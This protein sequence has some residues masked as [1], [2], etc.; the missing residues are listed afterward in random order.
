[1]FAARGGNA[2]VVSKLLDHVGEDRRE[3]YV[4][5]KNNKGETPLHFATRSGEIK[6]VEELLQYVNDKERY[7]KSENNK[8][9]TPLHFA[10]KSGEIKVV[11]KLLQYV[12]DKERYVKS[13]NNKGETPLH[14]AAESGNVEVVKGLLKCV[15]KGKE[16]NYIEF[17]NNDSRNA[18]EVAISYGNSKVFSELLKYIKNSK[19]KQYY[20]DFKKQVSGSEKGNVYSLDD[21]QTKGRVEERKKQRNKELIT[22]KTHS[23]SEA[24]KDDNNPCSQSESPTSPYSKKRSR[25]SDGNTQKPPEKKVALDDSLGQN[26]DIEESVGSHQKEDEFYKQDSDRKSD[27]EAND[28]RSDSTGSQKEEG[29]TL[30]HDA[31][32]LG[33]NSLALDNQLRRR[34][35]SFER[36]NSGQESGL[37]NGNNF[38]KQESASSYKSYEQQDSNRESNSEKG[39]S[40]SNNSNNNSKKQESILEKDLYVSSSDDEKDSRSLVGD[41]LRLDK[42]DLCVSSSNYKD[43]DLSDDYDSD[44][45]S[46]N[47]ESVCGSPEQNSSGPLE[48][49][50]NS[51]ERND[52][53]NISLQNDASE[54]ER[55]NSDKSQS[56]DFKQNDDISDESSSKGSL[57]N[58][59][60]NYGNTSPLSSSRIIDIQR[61]LRNSRENTRLHRATLKDD[62]YHLAERFLNEGESIDSM[63][64]EGRTPLHWAYIM[65]TVDIANLLL[66]MGANPKIDDNYNRIPSQYKHNSNNI[67][68]GAYAIKEQASGVGKGKTLPQQNSRSLLEQSGNIGSDSSSSESEKSS[69]GNKSNVGG[70]KDST[71]QQSSPD[72]SSSILKQGNEDRIGMEHDYCKKNSLINVQSS[73]KQQE[74]FSRFSNTNE[75]S[76]QEESSF[77]HGNT[78]EE[79]A[80]N[81]SH[82]LSNSDKNYSNISLQSNAQVDVIK[83]D[84]EGVEVESNVGSDKSYEQQDSD[85]KSDLE[86]NN[87]WSDSTDSQ[88]DEEGCTLLHIA[89]AEGNNEVVKTLLEGGASVDSKDEKGCTPLHDAV[90]EDHKGVA[91]LLIQNGA[92][93]NALNSLKKSP[94]ILAEEKSN[95]G[96][97]KILKNENARSCRNYCEILEMRPETNLNDVTSA[98]QMRRRSAPS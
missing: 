64:D 87:S 76:I 10:T 4:K 48:Q 40:L 2:E 24:V 58:S 43:L 79:R 18:L 47:R 72:N 35:A 65:N 34:S 92:N 37:N 52:L 49:V 46:S 88:K 57:G 28:S 85:R 69:P 3:D 94:F 62:R 32:M 84:V 33:K 13:E 56:N 83:Q 97:I 98:N 66:K 90:V 63:D 60:E 53:Q 89:A 36:Q 21:L 8:G 29:Y 96:L 11:E 15:V 61:S 51:S 59:G 41:E 27:S 95:Q 9:E 1:H 19:R 80:N 31:A 14:F 70:N 22:K 73:S 67:C 38:Q 23:H 44:E 75:S 26:V 17:A 12:N 20:N 81:N 54:E 71:S 55:D 16:E 91:Q 50:N 39:N 7:V 86:A 45:S 77:K 6:V 68:E 82:S 30:L 25:I 74:R 78:T 5:S 93:V 42:G